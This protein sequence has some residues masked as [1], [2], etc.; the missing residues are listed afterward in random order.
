MEML[1]EVSP[2][3]FTEIDTSVYTK[4]NIRVVVARLDQIHPVV[5][6]NKLFKLHFFLEQ[7]LQSSC[8]TILTFGGAYSNH[9]LATAYACKIAGL[10]S[11]GIVRGEMPATLSHTLEACISYGMQLEFINR[12]LYNNKDDQDFLDMLDKKF[13]KCTVI[14]EGGYAP[15]GAKGA[16]LIMNKLD[17][18]KATH[19]C[20]AVGA[21]TTVAGLLQNRSYNEKIIAIPVLKNMTDIAER[22]SFLNQNKN[23]ENLIIF[24][25]YHF[26][27]YAKKTN[28]LIDFMNEFY[29]KH[30]LP[31][32]FVYTAKMMYA[33]IDKIKTGYFDDGDIIVCLHTGGLQGNASLPAGTLVF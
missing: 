31:T 3:E 12:N 24:D 18:I 4:K 32:D 29:L 7:A 5:S 22:I 11:I 8:K 20:T 14:P 1:F 23:I 2:L 6:G 16:A 15:D 26:G 10:K 30:H 21:A 17:I 27:G 28:A 25:E 13:G 19:V 33:I 9:L